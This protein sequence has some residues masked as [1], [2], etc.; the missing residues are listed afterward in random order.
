MP[1]TGGLTVFFALA[2]IALG[3]VLL[4][5]EEVGSALLLFAI[6]TGGLALVALG[7]WIVRREK[8]AGKSQ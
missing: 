6:G 7:C 3:F 2:L 4:S 1:L 5:Y 8:S